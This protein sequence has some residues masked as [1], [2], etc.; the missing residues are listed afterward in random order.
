MRHARPNHL[1]APSG[2][3]PPVFGRA[4]SVVLWR[5]VRQVWWFRPWNRVRV[6]WIEERVVVAESIYWLW[7]AVPACYLMHWLDAIDRRQ[8]TT[9]PKADF[10]IVDLPNTH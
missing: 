1:P 4:A 2:S 6:L 10:A 7:W 8:G 5:F 3:R 9:K